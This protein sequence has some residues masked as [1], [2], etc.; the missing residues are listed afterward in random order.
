MLPQGHRGRGIW[1]CTLLS[2]PRS[3]APHTAAPAGASLPV[4]VTAGA[5]SAIRLWP[6][7]ERLQLQQP[8]AASAASAGQAGA[9]SAGVQP[10]GAAGGDHSPGVG[11]TTYVIR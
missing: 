3:P 7:A 5:D 4:L 1:R 2:A 9:H 8:A 10:P 11:V 6:L